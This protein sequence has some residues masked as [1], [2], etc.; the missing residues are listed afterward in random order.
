MAETSELN[1]T[2]RE[3]GGKGAARAIRREGRVPAVIYGDKKDPESISLD[4]VDILKALH[5]GTFLSTVFKI[6]V[7]GSGQSRV[8]PRDIQVDPIKDF[9]MHVDFL[10]I[11][12]DAQLVVEIAVHFIGEEESPGM[13]RGGVLNIV[14]H[15]IEV[16]APADAIPESI[17]AD[18][19]E[20]DIGDTLH[21]S[22]LKLPK[23]VVLTIT[24]RDFTVASLAGQVAEEVEEDV[25]IVE[26]EVPTVGDEEADGEEGGENQ[27]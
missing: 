6:N 27:E 2:P 21:A 26:G 25:D 20:L 3:T 9:P 18:I 19:S 23:G 14:R 1:A 22:A 8:I 10:R 12:K 15:E 7:E 17:E 11:A 5:T 13:K 16:S 24:D 4:F